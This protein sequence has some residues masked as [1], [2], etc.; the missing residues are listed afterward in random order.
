[1][2]PYQFPQIYKQGI[3]DFP[4]GFDTEISVA[5]ED[6][7]VMTLTKTQGQA[8]LSLGYPSMVPDF[9]QV[10]HSCPMF[11]RTEVQQQI[12][13]CLDQVTEPKP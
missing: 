3:C 11:F 10:F 5:I 12:W 13:F 2:P 9:F 6:L 8:E 4:P 1:M 7:V